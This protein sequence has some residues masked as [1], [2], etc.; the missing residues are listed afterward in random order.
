MI[1][2]LGLLS[3]SVAFLSGCTSGILR[4]PEVYQVKKVAIISVFSN[5]GV[6]NV[7]GGGSLTEDVS[8]LSSMFGGDKEKTGVPVA[9]FGGDH[10]IRYSLKAFEKEFAKVHGWE[11]MPTT[12]VVTSAAYKQYTERMQK[13]GRAMASL[14]K[15]GEKMMWKAPK[16]MVPYTAAH[17]DEHSE[18]FKELQKLAQELKVDAVA[19]VKLDFAYDPYFAVGSATAGAFGGTGTAK[20]SVA[21]ALKFV[22]K[23]GKVAVLTP[24]LERGKGKRFESDET[25][26]LMAGNIQFGDKEKQMYMQAIERSAEGWQKEIAHELAKK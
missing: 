23:E 18:D 11:V 17:N 13:Y 19:I 1:R 10:L 21:S 7:Q 4:K 22:T 26:M 9:D 16:G 25:T 15:F 24:D 6:Y 14:Q 12:D 20:A 2:I 8:K 5:H 3:L